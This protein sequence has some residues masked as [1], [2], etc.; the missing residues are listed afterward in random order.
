MVIFKKTTYMESDGLLCLLIRHF[1]SPLNKWT[2]R[3]LYHDRN[4]RPGI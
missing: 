2:Y 3:T 1:G 4:K